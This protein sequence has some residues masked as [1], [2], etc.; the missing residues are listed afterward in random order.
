MLP[1]MITQAVVLFQ[2]TSLVYV[3]SLRDFM[4]PQ[5]LSPTAITA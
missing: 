5:A 1:L 4:T 2:D 3:I